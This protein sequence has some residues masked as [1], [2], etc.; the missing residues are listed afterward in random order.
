M[1]NQNDSHSI[2]ALALVT[3]LATVLRG[4]DVSALAPVLDAIDTIADDGAEAER[5][6]EIVA[7]ELGG[8]VADADDAERAIDE[9]K[10][11]LATGR[12]DA[13]AGIAAT[14]PGTLGRMLG[15]QASRRGITQLPVVPGKDPCTDAVRLMVGDLGIRIEVRNGRIHIDDSDRLAVVERVRRAANTEAV[16][17]GM[18]MA[19]R[20]VL[21]M[22]EAPEDFVAAQGPMPT[23]L[24]DED[25]VPGDVFVAVHEL[26]KRAVAAEAELAKAPD[27]AEPTE[28][29]KF[30]DVITISERE[31][32]RTGRTAT[33]DGVKFAQYKSGGWFI[34]ANAD[35]KTA[36]DLDVARGE[37]LAKP[38]SRARMRIVAAT[39]GTLQD[40]HELFEDLRDGGA[41]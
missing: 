36:H 22:A 14:E 4:L 38:E 16:A 21:I 35:G 29:E 7:R 24:L 30:A 6:R 23:E 1:D 28:T 31:C 3:S 5:I 33:E 17:A 13:R 41:A 12:I 11:L 39:N 10:T 20:R 18:S 9:A 25:T 8:P 2:G 27:E 34:W 37:R 15:A 32:I 19:L 26:A 40:G